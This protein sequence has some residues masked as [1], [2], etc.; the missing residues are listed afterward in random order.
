MEHRSYMSRA[1]GASLLLVYLILAVPLSSLSQAENIEFSEESPEHEIIVLSEHSHQNDAFTQGLEMYNGSMY[2][3]TGLYGE[4]TLREVNPWTGQIIRSISLNDS[5]FS[6]GI[7]IYNDTVIMLTWQSEIAYVFNIVDFSLI[8]TYQYQGEG[9]GICFDG[10]SLV[11]S[12]GTSSVSFRNPET[13]EIERII[14]ITD[15]FGNDISKIN[16]LECVDTPSGPRVLANIWQQD[17]I[18]MFDPLDGQILG[19]YDATFLSSKN[20]VNNNNVLNGIAYNGSSEFWITGKNWS[21][22][23]LVRLTNLSDN[24]KNICILACDGENN[25]ETK[26]IEVIIWSIVILLIFLLIARGKR[27]SHNLDFQESGN[28]YDEQ[29]SVTPL[30]R[31]A[32][33]RVN[34]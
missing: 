32:E 27:T 17:K 10:E 34:D 21:S 22:T 16:E 18:L 25:S 31:G 28:R 26:G 20:R 11:M 23:Y 7:T 14:S 6:E 24:N 15:D 4:S 33:V 9:W 12:N 13:F 1:T 5:I 2:E 8:S 29:S 30:Q 3:R 19:E